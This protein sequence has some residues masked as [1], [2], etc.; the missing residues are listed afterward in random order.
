[1]PFQFDL[2]RL[3]MTVGFRV[4]PRRRKVG[5][6]VV[7]RFRSLPVANVSDGMSRMTAG[8]SSLDRCMEAACWQVRQLR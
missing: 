5:G 1:M 6:D 7:E 3:D 4:L 2:W 8:G